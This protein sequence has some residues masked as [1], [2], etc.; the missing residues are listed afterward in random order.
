MADIA[1]K[2]ADSKRNLEAT[3]GQQAVDMAKM[4]A[5][6]QNAAADRAAR[7]REAELNVQAE[8]VKA[9]GDVH[10]AMIDA[11]ADHL[12]AGLEGAHTESVAGLKAASDQKII[13]L[14]TQS[15]ERVAGMRA[16]KTAA[17]RK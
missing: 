16:K 5:D 2:E 15:A 13:G 4:Q 11:A 9:R 12:K 14:K 1:Q 8:Q 7:I 6:S 17:A 10:T 3:Q